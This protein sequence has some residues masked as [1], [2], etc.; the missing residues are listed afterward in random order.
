MVGGGLSPT[1]AR[2]ELQ[3]GRA[4]MGEVRRHW[5]PGAVPSRGRASPSHRSPC[6]GRQGHRQVVQGLGASLSSSVIEG[7]GL[8][9]PWV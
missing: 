2:A 1:H 4:V 8:D 5:D 6:P 9:G 3:K 7:L